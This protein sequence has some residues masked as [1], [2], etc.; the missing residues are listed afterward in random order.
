[1]TVQPGATVRSEAGVELGALQGV[2]TN[3]EG[4]QELEVRGA[5]GQLRAVPLGGLRQ[6]GDAL[7][8][9]WT[10]TQFDA[11]AVIQG[12]VAPATPAQPAAPAMP[13]TPA[14]P[15]MP[16]AAPDPSMPAMP[17]TPATPATPP[18]SPSAGENPI[19]TP[20][21]PTLP[22]ERPVG[23]TPANPAPDEATPPTTAPQG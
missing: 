13:A 12:G 3:A 22:P 8:V 4:A 14:A 1:M 18:A 2:R 10:K 5:D 20:T 23:T 21:P 15:A 19:P 9:A 17:A 6:D 16:G 7:V 11:S